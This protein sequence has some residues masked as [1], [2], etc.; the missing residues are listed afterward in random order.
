LELNILSRIISFSSYF[1]FYPL[2]FDISYQQSFELIPYFYP[3]AL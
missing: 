3:L 1:Y 2:D